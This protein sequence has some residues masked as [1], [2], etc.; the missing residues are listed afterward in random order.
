MRQSGRSGV[1]RRHEVDVDTEKV[2]GMEAGLG[3][4]SDHG[5]RKTG[6]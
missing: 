3:W 5:V 6:T 4:S 2:V 1:G